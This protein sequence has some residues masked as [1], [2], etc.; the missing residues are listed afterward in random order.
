[1]SNIIAIVGRPNVGKSTLFNRILRQRSAIVD[2]IPG[3]TRDRHYGMTDWNGK[4]FT[5]IDTGGY[6]PESADVFEQAIREQAEI[7]I[8]EAQAV[9]FMVDVVDGIT[10]LDEEIARILHRSN[11]RVFLVVNKIDNAG[12]ENDAAQFFRLGFGEPLAISALGGRRIGDFLDAITDGFSKNGEGETGQEGILKIAIVG[13]PNVGKSSLANSL[14]GKRRNIVTDRP[15]TT[16]DAIDS[17]LKYH[18]EDILIIDTAGLRRK[19]RIRESVEFYSTI[20]S[21]KSIDRCD[22]ALWVVDVAAGVDKQDIRVLEAI[23]ERRRGIVLVANKWD[24]VEKDDQTAAQY[25]SD[26]KRLLRVYDYVPIVFVSALEKKRIYKVIDIAKSVYAE[27]HKRLPTNRLN[28]IL[29]REIAI[30]TPAAVRG[31]E[32][33]INYITQ[34]KVDPP[35]IVFFTNEPDLIEDRYKRFLEKKIRENFGFIGVPVVVMFRK[36]N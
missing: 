22:V 4:S 7:A 14:L 29:R 24:L 32:I 12:R 21:L 2:D 25:E 8:Q 10:P 16:R 31:K 28:E 20:R 36:K 5:I 35:T 1:M 27:Q 23:H 6:V 15:G 3:V 34:V 18:G 19:S 11:K 30:T 9:I 33:K 17:V 26:M 13:K